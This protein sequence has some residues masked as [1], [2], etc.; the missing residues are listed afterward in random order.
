MEY[1]DRIFSFIREVNGLKLFLSLD[2]SIAII[3]NSNNVVLFELRADC[4]QNCGF[5]EDWTN[6]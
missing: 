6:L 1:K 2:S 4:L 3:V 5:I